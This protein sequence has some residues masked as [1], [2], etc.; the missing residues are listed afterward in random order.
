MSIPNLDSAPTES[1]VDRLAALFGK[2]QGAPEGAS[3][4]ASAT[5]SAPTADPQPTAEERGEGDEAAGSSGPRFWTDLPRDGADPDRMFWQGNVVVDQSKPLSEQVSRTLV[6][7]GNHGV[8]SSVD[9][10]LVAPSADGS[11]IVYLSRPILKVAIED[12][13]VCVVFVEEKKRRDGTVT[14]EGITRVPTPRSLIDAVFERGDYPELQPLLGI[15]RDAY[16]GREGLIISH[17]GYDVG[18]NIIFAPRADYR[19]LPE[20]VTKE[21]AL[22]A[23]QELH[24]VLVDFPLT[25]VGRSVAV[26]SMISCAARPSLGPTPMIVFDA[27]APGSGK[28]LLAEVCAS[29]GLGEMVSADMF[30]AEAAEF[31][32]TIISSAM[33]GKG[34]IIVDNVASGVPFGSAELDGMITA[35][36]GRMGV[37]LLGQSKKIEVSTETVVFATGNGVTL[38]GDGARRSL[39]IR[40][41]AGVEDPEQRTGFKHELLY[42]WTSDSLSR[43]HR[44]VLVLWEAYRQAGRPRSDKAPLG[45][46]ERWSLN[47][48]DLLLWLGQ[49][50]PLESRALIKERDPSRE[51]LA[52]ILPAME[53]LDPTGKGLFV[54]QLVDAGSAMTVGRQPKHP[55]LAAALQPLAT[56]NGAIKPNLLGMKLKTYEGRIVNGRRLVSRMTRTGTRLWYVEMVDATAPSTGGSEVPATSVE[57]TT[58]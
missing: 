42:D 39:W 25:P 8:F 47:V 26:A 20:V 11:R 48:R 7:L 5:A 46:F 30:R 51:F 56:A 52:A 33:E 21:D 6:E 29:I 3:S 10:R 53:K 50:D 16:V 36:A 43:L 22:T 24:D 49:P 34:A 54:A 19:P 14:P 23:L 37:R 31:S 58:S 13:V 12:V 57:E 32:K 40:L 38:A 55:D 27:S 44:A 35:R 18:S 45:S 4:T 9:A 17:P 1:V 2:R 28:T 15:R 41:D